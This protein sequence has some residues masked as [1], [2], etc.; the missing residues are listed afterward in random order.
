[1]TPLAIAV[2]FGGVQNCLSKATKYSLFDAT[3]E[4][5]FIPLDHDV[6]IRGK[7][8][9][10]VVGARVGKAG[11]SVIFQSLLLFVKSISECIPYIAVIFT[12]VMTLWIS[13]TRNLGK[14]FISLVQSKD[15]EET[16]MGETSS[17]EVIAT[18]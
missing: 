17:E 2:F 18:S 7:A 9:I 6:K 3:K 15:E 4:M 14:M 1:M 8:P 12:V 13:A 11:G 10:D 5:T 16:A